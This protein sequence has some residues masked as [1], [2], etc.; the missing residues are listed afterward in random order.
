MHIVFENEHFIVVEKQPN[1]PTVPDQTRSLSLYDSLKDYYEFK[2]GKPLHYLGIVHRLDRHTGGLVVFSRHEKATIKL[3]QLFA[4]HQLTK[5]YIARVEGKLETRH[6]TWTDYLTVDKKLNKSFIS[7]ESD[8]QAKRAELSYSVQR[9][10]DTPHGI[11]TD[12]EVELKTGRQHQIRTQFAHRGHPILGDDKYGATYIV[13]TRQSMT[14]WS[15][16]L[17]FKLFGKN[18]SFTS[19]PPEKDL[20]IL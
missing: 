10:K 1:V 11:I 16:Y 13:N 18:Y 15:S 20:W 6:D 7:T 4:S 19:T 8:L 9:E 17:S 5:K 14:L 12:V 2:L 3:N